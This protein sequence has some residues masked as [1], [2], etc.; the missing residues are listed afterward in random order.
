[1]FKIFKL[2]TKTQHYNTGRPGSYLQ[3]VN[4]ERIHCAQLK[5]QNYNKTD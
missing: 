2:R 4:D 3:K 5:D 1:M